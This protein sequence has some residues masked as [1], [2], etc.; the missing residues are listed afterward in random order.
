M[1]NNT[2]LTARATLETERET[3]A[4]AS[5]GL[6]GQDRAL[7]RDYPPDGDIGPARGD[8]DAAQ[9]YGVREPS[10]LPP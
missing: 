10:T 5:C 4:T 9:G 8:G 7:Q 3:A 2:W 1:A 6:V